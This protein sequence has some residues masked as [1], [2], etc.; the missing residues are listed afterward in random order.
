[1]HNELIPVQRARKQNFAA[2]AN[3][4]FY[5]RYI[6][7]KKLKTKLIGARR[8]TTDAWVREC[9]SAIAEE[10]DSSAAA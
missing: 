4:L 7:T 5:A 6:N 1:M 9:I 10:A 2:M 3:A 8:Y